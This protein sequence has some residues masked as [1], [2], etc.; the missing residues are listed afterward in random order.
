MIVAP[1]C[2]WWK[3]FDCWRQY[4]LSASRLLCYDPENCHVSAAVDKMSKPG[5]VPHG[6]ANVFLL[7]LLHHPRSSSLGKAKDEGLKELWHGYFWKWLIFWIVVR[8]TLLSPVLLVVSGSPSGS[9]TAKTGVCCNESRNPTS[10][11]RSSGFCNISSN[12]FL[13][14]SWVWSKY[15]IL[16][17][18]VLDAWCSWCTANMINVVRKFQ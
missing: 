13:F 9:V 12:I 15:D 4:S 2:L 3:A 6:T 16:N 1:W 14:T 11:E 17:W 8:Q 5:G 18:Y 10:M 7:S